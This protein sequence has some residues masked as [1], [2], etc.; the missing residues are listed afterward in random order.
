MKNSFPRLLRINKPLACG[1]RPKQR[2]LPTSES[3]VS[4][5]TYQPFP[6]GEGKNDCRVVRIVYNATDKHPWHV[7][8]Y[9]LFYVRYAS[10]ATV[11]R[12]RQ[13][14][15]RDAPLVM[16]IPFWYGPEC[17]VSARSES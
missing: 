9:S 10:H 14:D 3:V 7:N 1:F 15:T 5:G 4:I 11:P 8:S 6:S 13:F 2:A 17:A 16:H 12:N